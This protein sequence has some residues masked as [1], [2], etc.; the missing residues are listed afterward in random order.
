MAQTESQPLG[1][2]GVGGLAG[3]L[4]EG[5]RRAGDRRPILLSPRNADQS[6]RLAERFDCA[7]LPTNQAVVDGAAIV[8]VTTPP[9]AT[10]AAI[11]G[12][13]WRKGQ[14]LICAA[15]DV[16]VPLLAEAAAPAVAVRIMPS[17]SAAVNA[18][19]MP[20]C[21]PNADARTLLAQL[22]TVFELADEGGFAAATA[23]AAYHLWLY[24]L[25]DTM[26]A[27]SEAAGLPR[28]AAVGL[29][30]SQTRAAATLALSAPPQAPVRAPLD[31]HGKPGSMTAQG[32][33][34]L[35]AAD[36]F[37]PWRAAAAA[38]VR[39]ARY[40]SAAPAGLT[41]AGDPAT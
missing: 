24:A 4:V 30:A 32:L 31:L 14:L 28:E 3:V 36:A 17:A 20:L 12:L 7:S 1:V 41:A 33:A 26:V 40:G 22:G 21:P 35:D 25:M 29:V 13:A 9:A 37:A 10:L 5:F 16:T 8:L 18:D 15:M 34:V 39:R 38:A 2:I 27:A 23:L 19:A 6:R 11:R